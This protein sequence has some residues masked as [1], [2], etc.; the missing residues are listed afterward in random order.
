MIPNYII[1]YYTNKFFNYHTLYRIIA[2]LYIF[3]DSNILTVSDFRILDCNSNIIGFFSTEQ[4]HEFYNSLNSFRFEYLD[5]W[6]LGFLDRAEICTI[7]IHKESFRWALYKENFII[8]AFTHNNDYKKHRYLLSTEG[9][10][11]WKP[12]QKSLPILS[13]NDNSNDQ[14]SLREISLFR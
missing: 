4:I 9:W 1:D 7:I 5:L 12:H 11:N 14:T 13:R 10:K 8:H 3:I 2:H 6:I